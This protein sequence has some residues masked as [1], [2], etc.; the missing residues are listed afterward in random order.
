MTAHQ[1]SVSGLNELVS[2]SSRYS[3]TADVSAAS[4]VI[5]SPKSTNI[6]HGAKGHSEQH[7]SQPPASQDREVIPDSASSHNSQSTNADTATP[8]SSQSFA[9]QN[10]DAQHASN[11]NSQ[12]E[13]PMREAAPLTVATNAGQKRTIEGYVRGP[14]NASLGE[15]LAK[16]TFAHR[17][18]GST[19]SAASSVAMSPREVSSYIS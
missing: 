1:A 16:S 11:E 10:H 12:T 14:S 2:S 9:S 13:I 4:E 15:P 17:R 19:V 7:N 6:S 18:T 3:S 5:T 8:P